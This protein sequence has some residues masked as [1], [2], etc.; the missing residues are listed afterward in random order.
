MEGNAFAGS[1]TQ[2]LTPTIVLAEE[3][4][5][6]EIE[7]TFL[8]NNIILIKTMKHRLRKYP[9][10]SA[11]NFFDCEDI[12]ENLCQEMTTKTLIRFDSEYG[13][14]FCEDVDR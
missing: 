12:R 7:K 6:P 3:L 4:V 8:T 10:L 11:C 14:C 5:S 1:I 13:C 9:T 2:D